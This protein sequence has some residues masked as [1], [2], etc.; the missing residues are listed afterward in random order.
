MDRVRLSLYCPLCLP[1]YHLPFLA[2]AS[3]G[4][5]A[6]FDLDVEILEPAPG[7][8]NITRVSTGGSDFC[9]TS[10]S[11]YATARA[12]CGDLAARF[13]AIVVRRS[14]M[15]ALVAAES[16]LVVPADLPGRRIGGRPD[17]G[18]VLEYSAALRVLG[19]GPPEIVALDHAAAPEALARGAI[20]AVPEFVDLLPRISRQSGITL[21]AIPFGTEVYASGLV[22][23]DH[24]APELAWRMRAALSATLERQRRDPRRGLDVL[25]ERYPEIDRDAAV[26]GWHLVEPNVFTGEPVGSMSPERWADTLA[27]VAKARGFASLDATTVYR[28]DFAAETRGAAATA[29]I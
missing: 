28:A 2:G 17:D 7:P 24:L 20:D 3:D 9:L 5:F 6:E 25:E 1:G 21:R 23:S 22:A 16:A 27:H 12:R 18:F 8:D 4:L 29:R 14:P 15:A 26:E 13:I 11:H 10:V 19:L